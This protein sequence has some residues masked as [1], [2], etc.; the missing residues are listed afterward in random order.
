ML[1][2]LGLCEEHLKAPFA[3]LWTHAL[4]VL[5]EIRF[6]FLNPGGGSPLAVVWEWD[7]QLCHRAHAFPA[8]FNP[9][10]HGRVQLGK[11]PAWKASASQCRQF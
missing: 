10:L 4:V 9:E 3:L 5:N 11:T 7:P 2:V 8:G 6:P 1:L